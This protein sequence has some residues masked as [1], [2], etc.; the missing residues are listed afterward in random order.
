MKAK[1]FPCS[2]CP[3]EFAHASTLKYHHVTQHT[4]D[5]PTHRCP[6]GAAFHRK[7]TLLRHQLTHLSKQLQCG[8]CGKKF[9]RKDS[10]TRHHSRHPPF[11][12]YKYDTSSRQ[13]DF[14][15][16]SHPIDGLVLDCCGGAGTALQL[17]L[18]SA[19]CCVV[20]N[21][22]LRDARHKCD[23]YNY[24]SMRTLSTKYPSA[25]VVTSP[26]YGKRIQTAIN[27]ILALRL[28]LTIMKIPVSVAKRQPLI[29]NQI[30]LPREP[31]PGFDLRVVTLER[32]FWPLGAILTFRF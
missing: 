7:S 29:I 22:K 12:L 30:K 11:A 27:N 6:C 14:L 4:L 21:D 19:G 2:L 3:K 1:K 31:Y 18:E 24:N 8:V 5:S 10:L 17:G 23:V 13:L 9:R 26:P 20:T 16:K 28:P 25:T 32:W 15:L